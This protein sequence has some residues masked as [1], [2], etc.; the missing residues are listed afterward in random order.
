[1]KH[2]ELLRRTLAFVLTVTMLTS[3]CTTGYAA[4]VGGNMEVQGT[5]STSDVGMLYDSDEDE[6]VRRGNDSEAQDDQ[7]SE[8]QDNID[9]DK[10]DTEGESQDG[11]DENQGEA[12]D[13]SEEKPGADQDDQGESQE[14]ENGDQKEP[15]GE[16]GDQDKNPDGTDDGSGENQ[17][18]NQGSQGGSQG[19]ENNGQTQNPEENE[20]D[21]KDPA[22][23]PEA[24]DTN[25]DGTANKPATDPNGNLNDKK[26]PDKNQNT[27]GTNADKAQDDLNKIP[28]TVSP[29]EFLTEYE[30]FL[31]KYKADQDAIGKGQ[32]PTEFKTWKSVKDPIAKILDMA[33][34]LEDPDSMQEQIQELK[35]I[36]TN[37]GSKE[38]VRLVVR[39]MDDLINGEDEDN[40][41]LLENEEL[42][43]II[44]D[45]PANEFS[46]L[47][48][49]L[50]RD[51]GEKSEADEENPD[52][53]ET[54]DNDTL[55]I[56]AE[57][58]D[59][60]KN[61]DSS[62]DAAVKED[63]EELDEELTSGPVAKFFRDVNNLIYDMVAVLADEETAMSGKE[64]RE[65]LSKSRG[66]ADFVLGVSGMLQ[67]LKDGLDFDLLDD[68]LIEDE[69]EKQAVADAVGEFLEQLEQITEDLLGGAY[70]SDAEKMNR[71]LE[72]AVS[73]LQEQVPDI[74]NQDSSE[75]SIVN[76]IG[77]YYSFINDYNTWIKIS[78]D[79]QETIHKDVI[80]RQEQWLE[81]LRSIASEVQEF[82][83]YSKRVEAILK[84][85]EDEL[86]EIVEAQECKSIEDQI[87]KLDNQA[88]EILERIN[89]KEY[90]SLESLKEELEQVETAVN[91]IT[92]QTLP[93]V[94]SEDAKAKLEALP[95]KIKDINGK[96]DEKIAQRQPY[97]ERY[98][99]LVGE[100]KIFLGQTEGS[101]EKNWKMLSEEMITLLGDLERVE[102]EE[103]IFSVEQFDELRNTLATLINEI[104]WKEYQTRVNDFNGKYEGKTASQLLRELRDAED[105]RNINLGALGA[106]KEEQLKQIEAELL[107]TRA[108]AFAAIANDLIRAANEGKFKEY[109]KILESGISKTYEGYTAYNEFVS[110]VNVAERLLDSQVLE[111]LNGLLKELEPESENAAELSEIITDAEKAFN[112]LEECQ[113]AFSVATKP[114]AQKAFELFTREYE[115]FIEGYEDNKDEFL[116]NWKW[117][118]LLKRVTE[119]EKLANGLPKE[120]YVQTREQQNTLLTILSEKAKSEVQSILDEVNQW[121]EITEEDKEPAEIICEK[122][123]FAK[124]LID[125]IL[126]NSEESSQEKEAMQKKLEFLGRKLQLIQN[127]NTSENVEKFVEA[128]DTFV[129]MLEEEAFKEED[130]NIQAYRLLSEYEKL[131]TYYDALNDVEKE[132]PQV[133]EKNDLLDERWDTL[134]CK[135][136]EYLAAVTMMQGPLYEFLKAE[137]DLYQYYEEIKESYKTTEE[138]EKT[139]AL[140]SLKL[141]LEECFELK[142]GVMEKLSASDVDLEGNID[143]TE[144]TEELNEIKEWIEVEEKKLTDFNKEKPVGGLY[145]VGQALNVGDTLSIPEVTTHNAEEFIQLIAA[146]ESG[147]DEIH[148]M[149]Q[150]M[151]ELAVKLQNETYTENDRALIKL[152]IK[153][154]VS[155]V[156]KIARY[157]NYDNW[158]GLVGGEAYAETAWKKV[159]EESGNT[160]GIYNP[161]SIEISPMTAD[162]LGLD[163]FLGYIENSSIEEASNKLE[164]VI[165]KISLTRAELGA[166]QNLSEHIVAAMGTW[167]ENEDGS[168]PVP[169]FSKI[170][171]SNKYADIE[172]KNVIQ[173]S[174]DNAVKIITNIQIFEGVLNEHHSM[175]QRMNE[176]AVRRFYY[177]ESETNYQAITLEMKALAEGLTFLSEYVNYDFCN[178]LTG[179]VLTV[180]MGWNEYDCHPV[181]IEIGNMTAEGL[182]LT[183]EKFFD[184][185]TINKAITLV[186]RTRSVLGA[187]Q[188]TAEHIVELCQITLETGPMIG[189]QFERYPDGDG[190]DEDGNLK[191]NWSWYDHHHK[192]LKLTG[193]FDRVYRE[194]CDRIEELEAQKKNGTY[195]DEDRR[196]IDE[197]I[198][199]LRYGVDVMIDLLKTDVGTAPYVKLEEDINWQNKILITEDK[200]EYRYKLI[201]QSDGSDVT[202]VCLVDHVE[203]GDETVYAGVITGVDLSGVAGVT[204]SLDNYHDV[205]VYVKTRGIESHPSKDL[206]EALVIE[207]GEW[208][209]IDAET[210]DK[211]SYVD[212]IAFDFGENT[213]DIADEPVSVEIKMRSIYGGKPGWTKIPEGNEYTLYNTCKVYQK[214]SDD[215]GVVGKEAEIKTAVTIRYNEEPDLPVQLPTT[216]G[217]G[218]L[219]FRIA[220]LAFLVLAETLLFFKRDEDDEMLRGIRG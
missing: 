77:T 32:K 220:G 41:E 121:I 156:D 25:Q 134:I 55:A 203:N 109:T 50:I 89:K 113:Q 116:K 137:K 34:G 38:F 205:K 144:A 198:K 21:Q 213:F 118:D 15:A 206:P 151:Q 98:E 91:D 44:L 33:D 102:T 162:E 56:E 3:M 160:N 18:T 194:T 78:Q 201:Y 115:K 217:S 76:F 48:D 135:D 16:S 5:D 152:E 195:S 138:E 214:V 23:N 72:D 117:D 13:A 8:A 185:D 83:D 125:Y 183:D 140:W 71:L 45:G 146:M 104:A 54:N 24:P 31:E 196:N 150:R 37:E 60:E 167:L 75:N 179:G 43:A 155:E 188:N 142:N 177:E 99:A 100:S 200:T 96:I 123:D 11:Q 211:W 81:N 52:E 147:V 204:D 173:D 132:L 133:K 176:L 182:K 97:T 88:E 180:P 122:V 111:Q 175:L 12:G 166:R 193:W 58:E 27:T 62:N 171:N 148:S 141:A 164:E 59:A 168:N 209:L 90:G 192:P 149:S 82:Q 110:D 10:E 92:S 29:E 66:I 6:V 103:F 172:D 107:K 7:E 57:S 186:S 47:I 19:T 199:Q 68:I 87:T 63:E 9:K 154:L 187:W 119:L 53:A 22:D 165:T 108:K 131:L 207:G 36:F 197:E 14:T 216:G 136:E 153:Q 40:E 218:T 73:G 128:V 106:D 208:E 74:F 184:P 65:A 95:A 4:D 2:R 20:S 101:T 120:L 49:E 212:S 1:M 85:Y 158:H 112:D 84:G 174:Y 51:M 190:K 189:N 26:D 163:D 170:K 30:A 17:G 69:L 67:D 94:L 127:G 178:G 35:D 114:E 126:V 61:A 143:F 79:N 39:L 219:P 129:T 181:E 202:G 80:S 42:E 124:T 105:F 139:V 28:V 215:A 64:L 70:V 210:Y 86:T 130:G 93:E 161:M 145:I 46:Q 169:E 157:T 191:P 159:G